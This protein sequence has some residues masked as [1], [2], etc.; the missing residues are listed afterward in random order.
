MAATAAHQFSDGQEQRHDDGDDADRGDTADGRGFVAGKPKLEGH[1]RQHDRHGAQ[2]D[3]HPE[4]GGWITP[5]TISQGP[6]DAPHHLQQIQAEVGEHGQDAAQLDHG[7]EG[8]PGI[9]PPQ[10]Q[11]HHL[12]VSGAADR[13]KL[14]ET[15]HHAE[16]EGMPAGD[17]EG[18][19]L[20][21]GRD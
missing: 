9:P 7:G 19:S 16:H 15:L 20:S 3:R 1:A 13:Q 17:T 2:G 6:A 11:R 8:H 10:H 12:Q 14:R 18:G 4:P 5:A 21:N